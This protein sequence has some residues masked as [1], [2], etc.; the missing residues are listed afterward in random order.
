MADTDQ[1]SMLEELSDKRLD[2]EFERLTRLRDEAQAGVE[3]VVKEKGRRKD[4]RLAELEAE[5]QKIMT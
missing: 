4:A 1:R 3:E 2:K 5:L